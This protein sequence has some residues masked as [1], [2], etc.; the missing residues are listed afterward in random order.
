MRKRSISTMFLLKTAKNTIGYA[1]RG[2]R[3]EQVERTSPDNGKTYLV[4]N[5]KS[6]SETNDYRLTNPLRVSIQ[7]CSSSLI[8]DMPIAG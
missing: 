8:R 7:D 6:G 4:W 5:Q 1:D 3:Y 2:A